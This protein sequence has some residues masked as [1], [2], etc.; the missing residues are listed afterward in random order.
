[1]FLLVLSVFIMTKRSEKHFADAYTS[2]HA[3]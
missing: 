2:H 1:M 3:D